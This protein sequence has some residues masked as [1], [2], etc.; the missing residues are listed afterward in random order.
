M[1]NRLSAS[2]ESPLDPL[3]LSKFDRLPEVHRVF[4]GGSIQIYDISGLASTDVAA[5]P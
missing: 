3:L 2:V 4:D 1:R 5:N